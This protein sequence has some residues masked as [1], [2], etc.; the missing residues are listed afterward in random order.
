DA[1][2]DVDGMTARVLDSPPMA[3]ADLASRVGTVAPYVVPAMGARRFRVAALDLGIK[4]NTLRM[5]AARGVETH[6]LPASCGLDDV[7]VVEPDGVF[8]SNG[9]G[10]PAAMGGVVTLTR[11]IL[12]GRIPLFGICFGN[13]IL[14]LALGRGTYKMPYGHRGLNVP[15]V[16]TAR[17]R[18]AITAQNQ[19]FAVEGEAGESF[20]S[21][22]GRAMVSHH[23]PNDGTLDGLRW[24]DAPA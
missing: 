2:S 15:V 10:D 23:C 16:D 20:D 8:L 18:V 4:S 1:L 9:P 14:G 5:M 21:Q 24:L 6:V 22:F 17:G 13:Q 7:L 3:G 12:A 19:R 11:R